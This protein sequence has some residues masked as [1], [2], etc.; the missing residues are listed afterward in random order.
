MTNF[1]VFQTKRVCRR[2]FQID[3]NGRKLAKRIENT[4]GKGEIARYKQ[5]LLFPQGFQEACFPGVVVWEWVIE[6]SIDITWISKQLMVLWRIIPVFVKIYDGY[7][8]LF[9]C[10]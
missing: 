6:H 5:F 7:R 9:Y 8:N 2:Q 4:V 1:R 3:E 10:V